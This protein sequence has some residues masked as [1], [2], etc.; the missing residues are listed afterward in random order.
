VEV[1]FN[2]LYLLYFNTN[3]YWHLFYDWN[4][5]IA[6]KW[7]T[8]RTL[9]LDTQFVLVICD[10][11]VSI[12]KKLMSCQDRIINFVLKELFDRAF[13]LCEVMFFFS[14]SVIVQL[15]IIYYGND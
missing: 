2:F 12:L 13:H 4:I 1:L 8:E 6:F 5:V 7:L 9:T 15:D 14:N 3:L 10:I 11:Q